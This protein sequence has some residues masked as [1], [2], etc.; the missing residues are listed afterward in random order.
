MMAKKTMKI[1]QMNYYMNK[2][3]NMGDDMMI[4]IIIPMY[5]EGNTIVNMLDSLI[6]QTYID[7]EVILV[8]DGSSDNTEQ[9]AMQYPE[10][11]SRFLY[12]KQ[13]NKGVS[14]ARNYGLSRAKGDY[15]LFLDAD[16]T[17]L[18]QY[19]E[20]MIV[21]FSDCEVDMVVCSYRKNGVKLEQENRL[22]TANE[23]IYEIIQPHGA[24]GYIGTKMFRRDIIEVEKLS[25]DED[26][27]FSEDLLFNIRYLQHANMVKFIED[28][29]YLYE[30]TEGSISHNWYSSRRITN[31]TAIERMIDILEL[32]E[33]SEKVIYLYHIA[34][35]VTI[36][37]YLRF[38]EK[39]ISGEHLYRMRGILARY[40]LKQ[41]QTTRDSLRLIFAKILAKKQAMA[42]KME[43][44]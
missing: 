33:Q 30:I 27:F 18:A 23:T 43:I 15:V 42:L 34:L 25:F 14:A 9:I 38:S 2:V 3:H 5:N 4:S 19:L 40:S 6:K 8:N 24:K 39:Q 41:M 21:E 31:M 32:N 11:D 1:L 35:I 12:L 36:S 7:F 16:D 29:L 13:E 28:A 26:I 44:K 22:L 17:I 20:K 37:G 10:K